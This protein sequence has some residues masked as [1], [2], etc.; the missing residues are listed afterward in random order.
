MHVKTLD[1]R[2]QEL[3]LYQCH[4]RVRACRIH[5]IDY[6]DEKA[7]WVVTPAEPFLDPFRVHPQFV[8]KH[9]PKA[10]GYLVQYSDNYLSY[11][12]Q[13]AFEEGYAEVS[14]LERRRE[15][16]ERQLADVDRA[17]EAAALNESTTKD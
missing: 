4:K 14:Q 17:I 12:P 8:A 10:G 15:D 3:P 16:L 1:D 6:D 7:Q 5:A 9:A 13:A 2:P 11:S